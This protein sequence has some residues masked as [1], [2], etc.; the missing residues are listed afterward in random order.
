[1]SSRGFV[2][3][4]GS[5]VKT[6]GVA[7]NGKSGLGMKMTKKHGILKVMQKDSEIERI[8]L[9]SPLVVLGRERSNIVMEDPETSSSHCQ[10]Q[11]I[12]S[13]YHL[14]DLHSTNGTFVNGQRIVKS[15]LAAGDRIRVGKTEFVFD[16][17]S[18]EKSEADLDG[19]VL[20]PARYDL[21]EKPDSAALDELFSVERREYVQ[22][23]RMKIEV[24]YGDGASETFE[25]ER[26]F[27]VGRASTQGRFS[28]DDELSR[29]HARF[30]LDDDAALWVE[31]LGSTNGILVGSLR[32]TKPLK[33]AMNDVVKVGKSKM[34]L[35]AVE[36]ARYRQPNFLDGR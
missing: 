24:T 34:K 21:P 27:V 7:S 30:F 11:M 16:L 19:R 32:V 31:D 26:E 23:M 6:N 8:P 18:D 9:S 2:R 20:S 28:K 10:I 14:F 12:G 33:I 17:V 15:R 3:E 5:I 4:N 29:R 35:Q 25:V 13:D 22:A 1:M 36:G